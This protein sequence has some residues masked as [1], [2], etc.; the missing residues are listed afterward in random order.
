MGARV[1]ADEGIS[2]EGPIVGVAVGLTGAMG[3]TVVGLP[4]GTGVVGLK[5]K[6]TSVA[7]SISVLRLYLLANE[8]SACI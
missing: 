1:G 6:N 5:N 8:S 7:E 4:V 3:A 2:V